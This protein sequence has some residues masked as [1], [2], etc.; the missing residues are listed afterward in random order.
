MP[1]YVEHGLPTAG[2]TAQRP[3]N[4]EA[5]FRYFDTTL[6]Q[7][8][9]W[10]GTAWQ[11]AAAGD[12]PGAKNGSAVAAVESIGVVR[13]TVLTLTDLSVAMVDAGAAGSQGS[14]K[15]YDFPVGNISILGATMD[16][17]TLAGAG[18]IGDTGALVGSIGTVAAAADNA[19]LTSTEADIIPSTSGT[20]SSGAGTLKGKSTT[21]L[22]ATFDGTSTAKDALLNLAVPDAGSSADDTVTLNGTIILTWV[23]HGDV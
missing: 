21:A 15:L 1:G 19:T 14:H 11:N 13:R 3:A 10:N 17:T 23:N 6:S 8:I 7:T 16:L 4:A 12:T 18:G 5:G 9:I 20:L 2:T 22:I